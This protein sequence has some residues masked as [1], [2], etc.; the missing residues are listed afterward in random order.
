MPLTLSDEVEEAFHW[1]VRREEL[2]FFPG[3]KAVRHK[4]ELI[5]VAGK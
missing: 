5:S 2:S 3:S 1:T 4:S